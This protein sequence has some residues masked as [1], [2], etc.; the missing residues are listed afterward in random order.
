LI[1][2]LE[3]FSRFFN[4]PDVQDYVPRFLNHV[5]D[6][7]G[8]CLY[9]GTQYWLSINKDMS[10]PTC[11]PVHEKFLGDGALYIW[12]DQ[13]EAPITPGFVRMLCNRLWNLK[14]GFPDVAK[15]SLD[16][17]PVADVP[18]RIR[19]GFARGTIYELA[20]EEA[21][22]KEYIGF[23]INLASRLQKYCPELGFIASARVGLTEAELTK[24]GYVRTIAKSIQG[25]P[26]EVIIVD[27]KEFAK[28]SP[29]VRDSLFESV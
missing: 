5:S 9:G 4:Q 12:L 13:P 21:D 24:H 15:R 17:V 11:L 23:C 16:D 29:T 27:K 25:F 18:M 7:V 2:D 3:G 26:R 1:Y 19:F 8:A 10:C 22:R 6:A 14:K 28:L 20:S